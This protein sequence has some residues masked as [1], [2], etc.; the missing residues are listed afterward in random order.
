MW[1]VLHSDVRLGYR[2]LS[3]LRESTEARTVAERAVRRVQCKSPVFGFGARVA[4]AP[5]LDV[6]SG[7]RYDREANAP[8]EGE[9]LDHAFGTCGTL[10]ILWDWVVTT[11]LPLARA[12]CAPPRSASAAHWVVEGSPA[13]LAG[14]LGLRALRLESPY[15][16]SMPGGRRS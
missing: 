14:L 15:V 13:V 9:T 4:Q 2:R 7:A 1:L 8:D 6:G 10:G 11:F 16:T 5:Q 3:E 12:Q